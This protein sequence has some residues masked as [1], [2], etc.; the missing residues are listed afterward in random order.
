MSN[1]IETQDYD[2][3]T[4]ICTRAQWYCHIV[5][6]H[7]IMGANKDAVIDTVHNPDE[8]FKDSNYGERKL[9]F[10]SSTKAT[11]GTKFDTKVVVE[12]A[13]VSKGEIVTAY[14]IK[15]KGSVGDALYPEDD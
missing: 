14:P 5:K 4:V 11:Y 1:I 7:S 15:T 13:D 6:G 9:F 3:N 2:G 8:V 10:K 12:Y